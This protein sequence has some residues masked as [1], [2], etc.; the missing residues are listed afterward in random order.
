MEVFKVLNFSRALDANQNV[1]ARVG[2]QINL[3]LGGETNQIRGKGI[4][5]Q[6]RQ[7]RRVTFVHLMR[8]NGLGIKHKLSQLNFLF[9]HAQ[10][11]KQRLFEKLWRYSYELGKAKPNIDKLEALDISY[12][13][14]SLRQMEVILLDVFSNIMFSTIPLG[15]DTARKTG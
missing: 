8:K 9:F 2:M 6:K 1:T 7:P 11:F 4:F 13:L 14:S 5:F 15:S 12:L 3:A 10:P